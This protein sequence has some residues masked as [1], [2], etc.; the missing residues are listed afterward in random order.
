[1]TYPGSRAQNL[2]NAKLYNEAEY[3][4]RDQRSFLN[5][6]NPAYCDQQLPNPI[7]DL[8]PLEGTTWYESA[9]L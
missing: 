8:V 5:G 6:G 2:P 3:G 9:N 4:F 7:R 1:M